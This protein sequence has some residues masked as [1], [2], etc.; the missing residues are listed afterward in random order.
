[1]LKKRHIEIIAFE[2]ERVV[3][4]ALKLRCHICRLDTEWLT[5]SEAARLAQVKNST[6]RHWLSS[7]KAHGI[8][9]AGGR[10]RICHNSL[11]IQR[12][13]Q[14][15]RALQEVINDESL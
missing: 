1:M 11:F 6:V 12:S 13:D 10:H 15:A 8:R 5:T 7:G 9:T 3:S 2:R 14:F 4:R